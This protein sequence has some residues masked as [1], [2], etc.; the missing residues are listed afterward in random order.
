[1]ERCE[2]R[3]TEDQPC[4]CSAEM[5]Y[6]SHPLCLAKPSRG[7][8]ARWD[9]ES[10]LKKI[11]NEINPMQFKTLPTAQPPPDWFISSV[12]PFPP[13]RSCTQFTSAL[14]HPAA[15]ICSTL[16]AWSITLSPH[17]ASLISQDSSLGASLCLPG[18]P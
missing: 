9:H 10:L 16:Q 1:M 18:T 7:S 14:P 4:T 15:L 8:D 2:K 5:R 11:K 6:H 3:E 17:P 12:Q 13:P